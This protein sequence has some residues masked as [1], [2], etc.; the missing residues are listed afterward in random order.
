MR[1]TIRKFVAACDICQ[2]HK[3]EQLAP[4]GLLQPLPI[5]QQVWEDI[6]MDFIDGL[7]ISNGKSTI[8]VIVDRLSKFAHFVPLSH[9][10][11][12]IGVARIF[13]DNIFKLHGV[14]RT[15]VC[16]R[17]STFTSLFWSE[18]FKMNGTSYNYSSAY[19]PQT[20]GQSEVVNRAVEMYLRCFTS[21][22]PTEWS[23]WLAWAE[24]CYNTK[25]HSAIK[26][27]PFEVVYGR[28]PPSL[29]SYISGM[30]QVDAIERQLMTRD[31]VI[32]ELLKEAQARMKVYD[33]NHRERQFEAGEWVYLRLQPYRQTSISIRKNLKLS[34]RYFGP[35]KVLKKIGA[36][37]Y[38]L[39]LPK[40]SR[41]HLV[42]HVSLLKKKI[43]DN[44]VVQKELPTVDNDDDSLHPKPQAIL[45]RRVRKQKKEVL[46]HWQGLSPA[47]ATWE[48][49]DIMKKQFPNYSL[50]DKA[51]F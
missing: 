50:E 28:P 27:T 21:S 42:F 14:P 25:L 51:A 24:Y 29:L 22:R 34:P 44:V 10:Y 5:P 13:F 6:Y 38:R 46:I 8:L 37:A 39:E 4:A 32:K 3:V 26:T 9:P 11:T 19:Y 36:V 41:I 23:K 47:E 17:Y 33:K 49:L 48:V 31:Q 20:D 12:A 16:D 18:L 2:R 43:G 35:F 7:P 40:D 15:I 45:D 1:S 30:T